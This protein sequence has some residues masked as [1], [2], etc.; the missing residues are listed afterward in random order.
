MRRRIEGVIRRMS[1][2][3]RDERTE[4]GA[5][6]GEW[7]TVRV[8]KVHLLVSVLLLASFVAGYLLHDL[9]DSPGSMAVLGQASPESVGTSAP[10]VADGARDPAPESPESHETASSD[11]SASP[12]GGRVEVSL[13]D[14]PAWGPSDAPITIVEFSDY[15]CPFCKRFW[16]QTYAK[17]TEAYGDRIR[18]V[19]RD[20]PLT[21]IH[22]RALPA[23]QLA[24]C[25]DDQGEYWAMHD[26]LFAEQSSWAQL[27]PNA[28]LERF[29]EFAAQ[30]GLDTEQV[31]ACLRDETHRAEVLHDVSDGQSYG[32][33]GTPTFFINGRPLVGAVPF[34]MFEAVINAELNDLGAEPE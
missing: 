16:G 23:A 8:K 5:Q 15:E 33:R 11:A 25:A 6:P 28:L 24:E 32:V 31:E 19:F 26:L 18:F 9:V 7:L 14:D 10:T 27:N 13:D 2:I 21:A 29:V 1:D 20:F 34:E 17:L 3:R 30:L 22:P 4:D 12:A